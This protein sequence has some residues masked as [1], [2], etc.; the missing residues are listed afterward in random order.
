[1]FFSAVVDVNQIRSLLIIK[2][3]VSLKKKIK[4]HP[5]NQGT[6]LGFIGEIKNQTIMN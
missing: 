5:T 3:V 1:M 4:I 6:F 2:V